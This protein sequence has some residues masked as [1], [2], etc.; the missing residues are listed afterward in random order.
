MDL[1]TELLIAAL[2]V[3][4]VLL[5]FGAHRFSLWRLVLPLGI[6]GWVGWKYLAGFP[7]QGND[8]IFE[9]AGAGIGVAAG[10]VASALMGVG[11]N[12]KGQ[13]MLTAGVAYAAFWILV[14]A[15]RIGFA[16]LATNSPS[17]DHQ[18]GL[19]SYQ[20]HI[21]GPA[22]WTAFFILQAVVMV[23]VRSLV[24]GARALLTTPSPALP[25]RGREIELATGGRESEV[26]VG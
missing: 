25:T 16:W 6:V 18:L 21:T 11:R 8:L 1:S 19:F 14:F 24:V 17:F 22:A 9:L 26:A 15:A 3:G 5:Q 2:I 4:S 23:V 20:N 12:A 7:T 10:L 13:V